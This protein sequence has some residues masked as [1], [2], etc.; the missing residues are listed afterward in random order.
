[1]AEDNLILKRIRSGEIKAFETL[2]K[3]YYEGLC[4]YGLT[5]VGTIE[6][7][8]EIVQ[9]LFYKMWKGRE[10]LEITFSVKAYL[11]GAV[12]N[13]SLQYLEHLHIKQ[14]YKES[15]IKSDK[16]NLPSPE[17]ELEYKEL[18]ERIDRVL[19]DL[20]ERRREI[21]TMSRFEGLKYSEIA[22]K[23]NLS[24]KTI[25]AE[26]TKALKELRKLKIE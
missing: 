7:A 11:Y 6:E 13:N 21:F 8:E 1:M 20:P 25:E 14:N 24:T 23:L 15:V 2:F 19:Y 17:E 3:R 4:R 18:N 26:M 5:Y 9:E 12:R 22:E 16:T 10:N